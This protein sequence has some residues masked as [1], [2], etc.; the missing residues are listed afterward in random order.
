VPALHLHPATLARP[1]RQGRGRHVRTLLV[2][3]RARARPNKRAPSPTH[4]G[5]ASACRS[6]SHRRPRSA[7]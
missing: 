7:R 4:R 5:I 1:V 3:S 2:A 6:S